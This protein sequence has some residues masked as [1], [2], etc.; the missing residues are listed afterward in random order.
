MNVN[1]ECDCNVCRTARGLPTGRAL[2]GAPIQHDEPRLIDQVGKPHSKPRT[3]W[4]RFDSQGKPEKTYLHCDR[5]GV[6]PSE[7]NP[8]VKFREVIE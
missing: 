4:I 6:Y 5:P 3:V 7:F 8:W 2:L 1:D